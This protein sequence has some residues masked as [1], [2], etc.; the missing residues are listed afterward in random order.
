MRLIFADSLVN[1]IA[2]V[3]LFSA[4]SKTIQRLVGFEFLGS[5][6][7]VFGTFRDFGIFGV[8]GL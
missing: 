8:L 2:K 1:K 3:P 7:Q 6:L 4:K 5:G